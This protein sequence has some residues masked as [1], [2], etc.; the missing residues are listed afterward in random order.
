MDTMDEMMQVLRELHE[1]CVGEALGM[2]GGLA[3][4]IRATKYH[5]CFGIS[6]ISWKNIY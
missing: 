6:G 4:K 1:V 5:H 2:P 3:K